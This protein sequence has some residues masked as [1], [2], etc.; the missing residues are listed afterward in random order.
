MIFGRWPG[1]YEGK[2]AEAGG[3][4]GQEEKGAGA[5]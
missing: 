2:D 3:Q 5:A 4:T 1:T